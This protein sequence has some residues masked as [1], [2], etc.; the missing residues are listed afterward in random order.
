MKKILFVGV[1]EPKHSNNNPQI[2]CFKKKG[3]KVIKFDYRKKCFEYRNSLMKKIYKGYFI[4]KLPIVPKLF[5]KIYYFENAKKKVSNELMKK[6]RDE[7]PDLVF[8]S[9]AEEINPKIIDEI[10]NYSKTYYYF[11]DPL[12]MAK[13]IDTQE[14]SKRTNFSSATFSD[15]VNHFKIN[16]ANV[17]HIV[18]GI[19]KKQFSLTK[20]K[21]K[22]KYDIVFAGTI[23]KKR[24]EFIDYLKDNDIK[25]EIFGKGT[26]NGPVYNEKLMKIYNESKIVLNLTREGTGFSV[27]V[28][29]VMGS[30][31][32]LLTQYVDDLK[33]F[34]T[35]GK[36]LDWF[37]NKE[38]CLELVKFYL[39]E[40]KKR[41]KISLQA[42]KKVFEEFLW[43]NQIEKIIEFINQKI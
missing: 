35:K 41:E 6:V 30:N 39:K 29:E 10:N 17:K 14:Y 28:F 3:Y 12:H 15:V 9:K 19:E 16:G 20:E 43:E 21:P 37:C 24:K 42:K 2:E 38:E 23:D 31:T 18:Q 22:K 27:R 4:F 25:I 11:M 33:L 40:N 36:E 32:L 5:R 7:K 34:F 8:I 13:R 26:K 1:F